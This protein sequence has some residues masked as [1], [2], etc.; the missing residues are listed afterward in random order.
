MLGLPTAV[1]ASSQLAST[2][3]QLKLCSDGQICPLGCQHSDKTSHSYVELQVCAD[4]TA[5]S[6][7]FY[8][9]PPPPKKKAQFPSYSSF[10]LYQQYHT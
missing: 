9:S 8:G 5:E 10:D 3:L 4:V 7:V 6:V 1:R 2:G